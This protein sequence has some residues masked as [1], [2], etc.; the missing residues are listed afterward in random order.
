MP[1]QIR[2]ARVN[3]LNENPI[4]LHAVWSLAKNKQK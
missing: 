1:Q 3:S 2:V 4:L